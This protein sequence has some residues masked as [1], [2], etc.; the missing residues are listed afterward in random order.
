MRCEALPEY[1]RFNSYTV[2]VSILVTP[3][4][5]TA[6]NNLKFMKTIVSVL[7]AMLSAAILVGCARSSA[8][9]NTDGKLVRAIVLS[10]G[11][12]SST[13]SNAQYDKYFKQ[14]SAASG[15]AA[16]IAAGKFSIN[17]FAIP[18]TE[19]D[20]T[21]RYPKG[22]LV[23]QVPWLYY[24]ASN[25]TWKG[26]YK[27]QTTAATYAA[28][29]LATA[30]GIVAGLEARLYDTDNDGYVD[31]IEADFKEGVIVDQITKNP[32]ET[33][34]VYRGDIDTKNKTANEGRAFDGPNFTAASGAKIKAANFDSTIAAGNIALFWY[35]T[36]GWV[37]TRAKEVNGI[38]VD[39]ADHRTY[40]ISGKMYGDAMR[41]SRDN[42]FISNRPGEFVNA[43]KYFGLNNNRKDL[44]ISLWLVPTTNPDAQGAPVGLTS[45][46]SAKAFLAKAIST[47]DARLA[48]VTI[49]ADG[50][51]VPRTKSWV[52]R[53][54]YAQL[55]DA[56][57]RANAA[58]ASTTSSSALLDYQIYL[59]YL[60]LNGGASDIGARFAG[61]NYSGF[62]HQIK[63]GTLSP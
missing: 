35:G 23:N 38:F 19:K 41:F 63:A 22:Y 53:D 59:L 7:I 37:M 39:G 27:G 28:A 55:D 40:N 33:Y 49:S 47:A 20:Y 30:T 54:V 58:L 42:I 24:D 44:K 21:L 36:D 50:K 61:F 26:G 16:I 9:A 25:A 29:A 48:N 17:G 5:T 31:R 12:D 15:V 14:G 45:N 6:W 1:S 18:G 43:Q 51:D 11:T 34:S 8:S 60:T 13:V 56:I 4:I 2:Q 32:D 62:E 3:Q 10:M 46:S 52:T 57:K